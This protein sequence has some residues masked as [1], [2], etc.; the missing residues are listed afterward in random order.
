MSAYNFFGEKLHKSVSEK[1]SSS[2]LDSVPVV[3]LYFSAH[4]CG[5]CRVFTPKLIEAYNEINKNGKVLEVIFVSADNDEEQF[6]EY[7]GSMP[8]MAV[9]F[10]EI[11]DE[12]N[13]KYPSDYVPKF[14]IL[15][16]DLSVKIDDAQDLVNSKGAGFID[17]LF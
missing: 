3:A 8:W 6:E 1:V 15:N 16:K 4:W 17:G 11:L 12:V 13:A 9:E 7:Y 14:T 5:P 2:V 10:D